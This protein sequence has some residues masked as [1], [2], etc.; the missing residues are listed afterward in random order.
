M[1]IFI[2]LCTFL[3]LIINSLILLPIYFK[4]NFKN[5]FHY[6]IIQIVVLILYI[7]ISRI[8]V[9]AGLGAWTSV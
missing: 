8:L 5:N 6:I 2:L 3:F 1:P 4:N 7:V 9:D